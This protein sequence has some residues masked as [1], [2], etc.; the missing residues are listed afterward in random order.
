LVW[1][2]SA[3]TTC[4]PPAF[5]AWGKAHAVGTCLDRVL[6]VL[7]ALASQALH[8]AGQ[9]PRLAL[10]PFLSEVRDL[11]APIEAAR[12]LAPD[13]EPW[14]R[15]SPAA[16]ERVLGADVLVGER[17]QLGVVDVAVGDRAL[18]RSSGST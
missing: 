17:D 10:G 6:A 7:A 4:R 9:P 16:Q 13:A 5:L 1:E 12:Q 2:A 14:P 18:E 8:V 11:F 3:R 15:R